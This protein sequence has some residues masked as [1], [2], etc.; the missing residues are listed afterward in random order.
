M[1]ITASGQSPSHAN[2][3]GA[4]N[5]AKAKIIPTAATNAA[6]RLKKTASLALPRAALRSAYFLD[7]IRT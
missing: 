2:P 4:L 1:K 7:I 6:T 3:A 5:A